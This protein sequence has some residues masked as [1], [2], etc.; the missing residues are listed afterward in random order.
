MAV[1]ILKL[2]T[3]QM[4]CH[5]RRYTTLGMYKDSGLLG[6]DT[7]QTG[8]GEYQVLEEFAASIRVVQEVECGIALSFLSTGLNIL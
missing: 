8:G 3:L 1:C 5:V 2:K 6:Q 7:L 4:S